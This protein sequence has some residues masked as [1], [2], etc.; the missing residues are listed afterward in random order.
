MALEVDAPLNCVGT[1]STALTV[2]IASTHAGT[3]LMVSVADAET[4]HVVA[5]SMISGVRA[6]T[7]NTV[8]IQASRHGGGG[9]AGALAISKLYSKESSFDL[10]SLHA[11]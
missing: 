8:P 3:D 1:L 5:I 4:T 11:P 7:A 9:G 10:G 6:S 2:G